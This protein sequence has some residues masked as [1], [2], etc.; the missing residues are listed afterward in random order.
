MPR[1]RFGCPI[2]WEGK[3]KVGDSKGEALGVLKV[4]VEGFSEYEFTDVAKRKW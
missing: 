1:A 2:P 4:F 3:T